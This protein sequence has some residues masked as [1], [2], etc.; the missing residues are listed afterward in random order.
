MKTEKIIKTL[1]LFKE[2][3]QTTI[4]I[5]NDICQCF[6]FANN[7]ISKIP[8]KQPPEDQNDNNQNTGTD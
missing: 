6:Q 5:C 1:K 7:A 2:K 3:T 8:E 4:G